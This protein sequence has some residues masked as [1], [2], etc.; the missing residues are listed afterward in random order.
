MHCSILFYFE[1]NNSNDTH[2]PNLADFF[3]DKHFLLYGDF[4]EKERRQL[5]RYITAYGG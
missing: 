1:G 4:D 5:R 2:T 3:E